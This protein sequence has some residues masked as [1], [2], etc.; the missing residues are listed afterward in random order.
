MPSKPPG[1]WSEAFLATLSPEARAFLE[2]LPITPEDEDELR[3][4]ETVVVI[5]H[6]PKG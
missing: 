4:G 1:S 2:S 6:A 3:E 5:R